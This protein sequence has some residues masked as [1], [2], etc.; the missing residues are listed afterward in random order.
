M[1]TGLY[2]V[3]VTVVEYKP[4]AFC[5]ESRKGAAGTERARIGSVDR[6][7]GLT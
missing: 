1:R 4:K 7:V 3:I 5:T 6:F 2:G